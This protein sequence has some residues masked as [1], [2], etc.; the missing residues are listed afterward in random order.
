MLVVGNACRVPDR[1]PDAFEASDDDASGR[2]DG[3]GSD[4]CD[5]AGAYVERVLGRIENGDARPLAAARPQLCARLAP[6]DRLLCLLPPFSGADG[7]FDIEVPAF[8]RCVRRA[9]L[10]VLVADGPYATAY[11]PLNLEGARGGELAIGAPIVLFEVERASLPPVGDPQREREVPLGEAMVVEL[12]PQDAGGE[13]AY[14][15]LGAVRVDP[16]RSCVPEAHGLRGLV[17]ATPEIPLSASFRILRSGLSPGAEVD[18]FVIGG[19]D[20]RLADGRVVEEAVLARFG[21]GRVD[22]D[23][24]IAPEPGAHLPH[25]GWL[26]W[27]LR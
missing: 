3:S 12:S 7:S 8:A 6:D 25:L 4:P 10:R 23:E 9:T 1:E 26:G 22:A 11:C 2:H 16:R 15:R 27:S 14:A 13:R 18:L 17:A 24:T 20:T 21:R 19:L 5:G